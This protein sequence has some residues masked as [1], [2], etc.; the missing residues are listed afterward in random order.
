MAVKEAREPDEER[1][2]A[3]QKEYKITSIMSH[4]N[5]INATEYFFNELTE[6]VHIV[7]DYVE[8]Q[9]VLDQIAE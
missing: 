9:E 1:R 8:G 4:K 5:V 3:H 2:L 7:M 6:E